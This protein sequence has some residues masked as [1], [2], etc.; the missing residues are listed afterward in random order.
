MVKLTRTLSIIPTVLIFSYLNIRL[1]QKAALKSQTSVVEGNKPNFISLFPI[2]ILG[3]VAL[4]IVNSFGV[5]P[6]S[7]SNSAKDVSKF[8]MVTALAAI[9][10]KTNFKEMKKSGARPML[11][12]FII[13]LLVVNVAIVVEYFMGLV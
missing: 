2:F 1:K 4:A 7:L 13:S 9:G 10:L 6:V 5:I 11:H 3:F 8:L 12:G